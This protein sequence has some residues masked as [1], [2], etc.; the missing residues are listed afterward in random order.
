MN[1]SG[2]SPW[3]GAFLIALAAFALASCDDNSVEGLSLSQFEN[4]GGTHLPPS[5]ELVEA[6]DVRSNFNGDGGIEAVIEVP[7][8]QLGDALRGIGYPGAVH[9]RPKTAPPPPIYEDDSFEEIAVP[10]VRRYIERNNGDG[11]VVVHLDDPDR[12]TLYL[13]I[14]LAS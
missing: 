1:R 14:G 5:A 2:G 3:P 13:Y 11:W 6:K 7:R 4:R 12:A 10:E 8:S 9:A